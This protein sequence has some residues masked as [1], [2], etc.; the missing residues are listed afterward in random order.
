MLHSVFDFEMNHDIQ[1]KKRLFYLLL[2]LSTIIYLLIII[3][4]CYWL[5]FS[6]YQVHY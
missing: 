6:N 1:N 3:C 2:Y 5:G 4:N